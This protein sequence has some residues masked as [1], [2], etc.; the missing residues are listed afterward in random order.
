MNAGGGGGPV[1]PLALRYVPAARKGNRR[2]SGSEAD[3]ALTE[4]ASGAWLGLVGE[5]DAFPLARG[6]STLLILFV[7]VLCLKLAFA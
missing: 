4:H 6:P 5:G 1:R 7:V 2:F 3:D